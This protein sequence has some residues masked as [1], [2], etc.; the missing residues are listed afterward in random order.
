M[1]F[2][3]CPSALDWYANVSSVPLPGQPGAVD[4]YQL[5]QTDFA[6]VQT[7]T[8]VTRDVN[9]R[10]SGKED[11]D[12]ACFDIIQKSPAFV[13]Q[14]YNIVPCN[15]LN[16][17]WNGVCAVRRPMGPGP[18]SRVVDRRIAATGN[19]LIVGNGPEVAILN[20]QP[21][22]PG[23]LAA[24]EM[25]RMSVPPEAALRDMALTDD[26]VVA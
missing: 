10:V 6:G 14:Q 22:V 15:S 1:A 18:E 17:S 20:G 19:A 4:Q 5:F 25:L 7:C 16:P 12:G 23:T 9:G 21:V 26:I 13:Q 8:F 24:T 2:L 3:A 11:V